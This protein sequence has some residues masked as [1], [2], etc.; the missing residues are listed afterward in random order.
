M[1]AI[2]YQGDGKLSCQSG[3][4]DPE[5]LF[6][7][8]VILK[9]EKAGICGSDLHQLQGRDPLRIGAT[10]GHEVAGIV[11]EV[12]SE[13]ADFKVGDR[14]F[15]PF[16]ISCGQCFFCQ[17]GLTARCHQWQVFGHDD[18]RAGGDPRALGGAQ[19]EFARVPH[20]DHSLVALPDEM[21]FAEAIFLA[22]NFSTGWSGVRQAIQLCQGPLE[23]LVVMGC[24]VVGL[25]AICA[26]TYLNIPNVIAIDPV[27]Y[28]RDMALDVRSGN[29]KL[30]SLSLP[31]AQSFI[32]DLCRDRN[33]VDAVVEA[34]GRRAAL[35]EAF[36]LIRPFGTICSIGMHTEPSPIGPGDEYGKN[37]IRAT[38]RASVRTVVE[39]ILSLRA[40]GFELP[41]D[42]L[43]TDDAIPFEDVQ[44]AYERFGSR[45][46]GCF[47]LMLEP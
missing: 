42:A 11:C 7:T 24:G 26:A 31:E 6:P 3:I 1:K 10:F 39:E 8:D 32:A 21:G 27:R 17:H 23:T 38:G 29:G 14:V 20:A 4:P 46:E 18:G 19:A 12:G 35:K 44:S 28:R 30:N 36:D 33:G 47:K 15:S 43:I 16:S 41:I 40:E 13:V 25:S 37:A 22:D 34:V 2:V 5:I 45:E 9:V